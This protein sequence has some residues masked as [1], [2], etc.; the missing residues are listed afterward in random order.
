MAVVERKLHAR[1]GLWFP[2]LVCK[3]NEFFAWRW[4][5]TAVR[6]ANWPRLNMIVHQKFR[7]MAFPL[8]F[9]SVPFSASA[10]EF[11]RIWTN[12]MTRHR[13]SALYGADI[14]EDYFLLI[15]NTYISFQSCNR[16][17]D[18]AF[19]LRVSSVHENCEVQHLE[20]R[21]SDPSNSY[22]HLLF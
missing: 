2:H 13:R 7:N 16:L 9:H 20:L 3:N 10:T 14:M 5:D 19:C 22:A 12:L 17:C 18:G 15:F 21:T 11:W 6:T 4:T 8:S 1:K